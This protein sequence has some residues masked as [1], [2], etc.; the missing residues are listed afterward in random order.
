MAYKLT[1][2]FITSAAAG[3]YGDIACPGLYICVNRRTPSGRVSR[4]WRQ[5]LSIKGR[6]TW[7]GLGGYPVVTLA[8]A[9]ETTIDNHR[10]VRRGGDPRSKA[11]RSSTAPSFEAVLEKVIAIHSPGWRDGGKTEGHWR[12]SLARHADPLMAMP[13][14]LIAAKDVLAVL[15][16]IWHTRSA[17]AAK[18]RQ[19]ISTMMNWSIA[20]G[21]RPDNPAGEVMSAAL[22]RQNG[23]TTHLPSLPHAVVG[24][25]LTRIAGLERTAPVT[26]LAFRFLV[27]TAARS[28]EVRGA[29][30]SE[31]DCDGA[32]WTIP[33]SRMKGGREHRAPLSVQAVALLREAGTLADASGLVFPSAKG[34]AMSDSTLSKLLRENGFEAVPHGFR[35]SLRDWTAELTDVPHVVAE[36]ALAHVEGSATVRAYRRTDLFEK[37]RKLMQKWA[38]YLT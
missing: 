21:F 30:W 12:R 16:P 32:V 26:R 33:A 11:K 2:Q 27:L 25:A 7:I 17:T 22:P 34:A 15:N 6:P 24:R 8:E 37:R 9:R 23:K 28:K 38:D 35:S 5:R 31:V 19:R 20:Q 14:D 4:Q 1:H 29:R 10:L 13:V 36:I 3:V 18:V